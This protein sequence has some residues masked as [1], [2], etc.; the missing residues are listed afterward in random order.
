MAAEHGPSAGEYIGH[1]LTHL[2][3]K[4]MVGIADFSVFNMDSMFW[5]ISLGVLGCFVMWLAASRAT[6]GVP[7]RLQSDC[8]SNTR[9]HW[10]PIV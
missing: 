8:L 3:N 2:Q 4:Q 7:G 9:N 6:S 10:S 5:A 1:H